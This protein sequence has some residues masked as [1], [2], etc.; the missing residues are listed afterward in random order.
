MTWVF[1]VYEIYSAVMFYLLKILCMSTMDY[2]K[3]WRL[4]L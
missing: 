1:E 3:T 4:F 2:L